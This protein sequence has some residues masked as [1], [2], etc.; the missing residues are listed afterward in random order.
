MG[1]KPTAAEVFKETHTRR[2]PQTKKKDI[3]VE[4]RAQE[5]IVSIYV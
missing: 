2:N 3:W 5:T 4:P 1:K